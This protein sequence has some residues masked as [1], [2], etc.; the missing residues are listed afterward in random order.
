[1]LIYQLD[2]WVFRDELEDWCR[3]GFDYIGAPWGN[4]GFVEK[5]RRLRLIPRSSCFPWL[6]GLLYRNEFRVGNG[7]FSL[8]NI[9]A[10]LRVLRSNETAV[11]RWGGNEDLF[12][13]FLGTQL[14]RSFRIAFEDRAMRFALELNPRAYVERMGGRLPFG[15]HAWQ[16]YDPDFWGSFIQF[17]K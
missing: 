15:C 7:G 12:W 9:R 4:A 1:M 2:A 3:Q 5:Y 10:F 17:S 11:S 16:K 13:S 6:S 14:D 8:R